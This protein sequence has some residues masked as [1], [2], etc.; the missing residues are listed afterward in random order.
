LSREGK[1]ITEEESRKKKSLE[2]SQ[3]K[4][5]AVQGWS[6]AAEESNGK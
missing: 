2:K 6:T 5:V 1:K 4:L 3:R